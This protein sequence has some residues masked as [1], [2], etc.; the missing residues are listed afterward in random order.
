MII[1]PT[2]KAD[3]D[4]LS[5]IYVQTWRDTYLG[6]LPFDYL[7][8][9]SATHHSRAFWHELDRNDLISFVAEDS[10]KILGFITG[11][12]ERHGDDVYCGEI[13][14]LYV[15][16][17]YQRRGLGQNLVAAL[18]QQF[19]GSGI[20][21]MLVRVLKLNPY[22]RF[23]VK[24]NGIYLKSEYQ[25]LARERLEVDVYGWLDLRLAND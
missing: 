7:F 22:R 8:E 6:I 21:S 3:T 25:R 13:F 19:E 2:Q 20:Y 16:K 4:V 12:L 11:G 10:G 24:R 5:R 17:K 23:Y 14:T 9:M 18:T 1:R 15:L